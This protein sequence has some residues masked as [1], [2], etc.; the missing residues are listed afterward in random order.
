[1]QDLFG[2]NQIGGIA[3]KDLIETPLADSDLGREAMLNTSARLQA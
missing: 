3:F 1:V 2:V